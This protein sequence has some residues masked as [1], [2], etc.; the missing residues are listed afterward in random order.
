MN[1][2]EMDETIEKE[3]NMTISEIFEKYGDTYFRNL[4]TE[5]LR[6][7]SGGSRMVVSCGG[8]TAM[9]EENVALMKERGTIVWLT[10]EPETVYARVKDSNSRPILN[11]NMNVAYIR[12]LMEKRRP[13]Y[14]IA[15]DIIIPTDHRNT[16]EICSDII[17][18]A[19][20][21]TGRCI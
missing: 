1:P 7:M 5:F 10:A 18:Q 3:Q 20:L 12:E 4:E 21:R 8:G 16:A 2:L 13:R 15:A 17:N 6:T 14:S 9:R 11:G 19:I